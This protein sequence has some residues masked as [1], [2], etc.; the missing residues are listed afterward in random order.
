M[1][2]DLQTIEDCMPKF[3]GFKYSYWKC[4]IIMAGMVAGLRIIS[5]FGFKFIIGKFAQ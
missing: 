5:A 3:L 2:T 4:I 1:I